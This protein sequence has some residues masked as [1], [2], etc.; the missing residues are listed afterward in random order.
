MD[1]LTESVASAL[2]SQYTLERQSEV[3][4]LAAAN[5]LAF[6]AIGGFASWC[7]LEASGERSHA[8]AVADYLI[9][10]GRVPA[11][12]ALDL[13]TVPMTDNVSDLRASL[14]ALF[15]RAFEQ[16]AIVSNSLD[17]LHDIAVQEGDTF[18]CIFLQS[19]MSEQV[20]AERDLAGLIGLLQFAD[21]PAAV[22]QLDHKYGK[23]E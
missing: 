7:R 8:A 19:F 10:R 15:T 3:V 6:H 14:I 1:S 9:D 11:V 23:R 16:E 22:L 20:R 21:C 2:N 18:T 4:Y 5:V 17:D 12:S 13:V